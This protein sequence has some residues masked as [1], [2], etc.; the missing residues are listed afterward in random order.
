MPLLCVEVLQN[1]GIWNIEGREL[2]GIHQAMEFLT[3]STQ[4]LLD[5]ELEDGKYLSVKDKDVIVI[6]GGDTGTDCVATAIRLECKSVIQLEIMPQLPL[7]RQPGNPWPEW[8][9]VLKTDY[10]Q[11]EATKLYGT[12]P[13]RYL[14]ASKC[15]IGDANGNV[16]AIRTVEVE[17]SKNPQG[18]LIPVEIP[19][20]EKVIPANMVLLALGF[21]GPEAACWNSLVLN[22]TNVP[23]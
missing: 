2:K 21:T 4:S 18:G 9:K 1:R 17:W 10:G 5:S 11:Q 6:G 16:E 12:D 22:V 13:R 23:T 14:T 15:F 7:S 20:S 8:P 19:G 3:R